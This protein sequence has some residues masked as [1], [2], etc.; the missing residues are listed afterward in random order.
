MEELCP[1]HQSR[2]G[3][4][5]PECPSLQYLIAGKFF[6]K[7]SWVS[8]AWRKEHPEEFDEEGEGL[9]ERIPTAEERRQTLNHDQDPVN[10]MCVW[11]SGTPPPHGVR[12]TST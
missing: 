10:A 12:L 8:E 11:S 5:G 1:G 3:V 7:G 6:N 9:P 4:D 2:L